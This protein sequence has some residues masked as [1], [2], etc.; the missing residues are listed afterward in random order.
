MDTQIHPLENQ[1][2]QD[3]NFSVFFVCLFEFVYLFLILLL[4]VVV[5]DSNAIWTWIKKQIIVSG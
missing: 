2:D 1:K 5:N 3:L 4:F